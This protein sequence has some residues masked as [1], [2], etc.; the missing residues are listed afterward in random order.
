MTN[1]VKL[2]VGTPITGF[3]ALTTG[4]FQN[5]QVVGLGHDWAV[6]RDEEGVIAPCVLEPKDTFSIGRHEFNEET[7]YNIVE[8]Q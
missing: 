1:W 4:Y 7:G 5:L 3:D 2:K 6:L 8:A